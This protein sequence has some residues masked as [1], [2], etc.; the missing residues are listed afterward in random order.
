MIKAYNDFI[1]EVEP[2]NEP[3][4]YIDY[5]SNKLS[6]HSSSGSAHPVDELAVSGLTSSYLGQSRIDG[7]H[8][9]RD[10]N[11]LITKSEQQSEKGVWYN[12]DWFGGSFQSGTP[13]VV[14][15]NTPKDTF[16]DWAKTDKKEPSKYERWMIGIGISG[17]IVGIVTVFVMIL[18]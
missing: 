2:V 8:I 1:K 6:E 9:Y 12:G 13:N 11:N 15:L 3:I 14:V 10:S 17:L 18:I 7:S 4:D 5:L 16:G